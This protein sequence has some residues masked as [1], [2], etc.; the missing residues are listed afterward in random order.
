MESPQGQR[1]KPEKEKINFSIPIG[2]MGQ[3]TCH[4]HPHLVP[5]GQLTC[6][7]SQAEYVDRRDTL[8]RKLQMEILNEHHNHVVSLF[9]LNFLVIRQYK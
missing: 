5:A 8:V 1:E 6:G 9:W 2:E 3:P 4:T 7:V